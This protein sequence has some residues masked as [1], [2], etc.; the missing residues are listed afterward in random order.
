[1]SSKNVNFS[2]Q[3][4]L[5]NVTPLVIS[6]NVQQVVPVEGTPSQYDPVSRPSELQGQPKVTKKLKI[7]VSK[8][9]SATIIQSHQDEIQQQQML[10]NQTMQ[11]IHENHSD[12][13]QFTEV[14]CG[15]TSTRAIKT[16]HNPTMQQISYPGKQP[17]NALVPAQQ[18]YPQNAIAP[19]T[20]NALVP[21]GL[22]SQQKSPQHI[23]VPATQSHESKKKLVAEHR[24]VSEHVE[25]R[26]LAE[27]FTKLPS[28]QP[29]QIVQNLEA[30]PS[31]PS[32]SVQHASNALVLKADANVIA[33]QPVPSN[34]VGIRQ[35]KQE[36]DVQ[37]ETDVRGKVDDREYL[38]RQSDVYRDEHEIR[39]IKRIVSTP[40]GDYEHVQLVAE[41]RVL[42]EA[43]LQLYLEAENEN[44]PDEDQS[45]TVTDDD[46][47]VNPSSFERC[48]D[49]VCQSCTCNFRNPFSHQKYDKKIVA[50]N[51]IMTP[52]LQRG[53]AKGTTLLKHFVFPLV[54]PLVRIGWIICELIFVLITII[55]SIV[56]FAT[57]NQ[58]V[59][60]IVQ[61]ILAFVSCLLAVIDIFYSLPASVK[62]YKLIKKAEEANEGSTIDA[63]TVKGT[64]SKCWGCNNFCCN[65]LETL[66]DVLRTI[67]TEVILVPLILCDIFEVVISIPGLPDNLE[68]F[69]AIVLFA[70]G[71]IGIVLYVY[72]VRLAIL[73]GIIHYVYKARRAFIKDSKSLTEV[74]FDQAKAMD[75]LKFKIFFLIHVTGQMICQVLMLV[76][77][78]RRI[79]IE[80]QHFYEPNNL[81]TS[82][83]VS[84]QLWYMCAAVTIL[85][86]FGFFTFFVVANFWVQQFPISF[87]LGLITALK[88]PGAQEMCSVKQISKANADQVLKVINKFVR[89]FKLKNQFHDMYYVPFSKKLQYPFRSPG[90][91]F[92]C[93]VYFAAHMCFAAFALVGE[94]SL[95]E[96][97]AVGIWDLWSGFYVVAGFIGFV[98]N[99]YAFA[100]PIF[101][102]L[103]ITLFIA[104]ICLSI[105]LSGGGSTRNGRR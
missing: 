101:W 18:V 92:I 75:A 60:N 5:P 3:L 64:C 87:C 33:R 56:S 59:F 49:I 25:Q 67:L 91:I 8:Q 66:S 50:K 84:S 28:K 89:V 94:V 48:T 47:E 37:L 10:Q 35:Q 100:V 2:K 103:V 81:D 17:Q 51:D 63:S 53:R 29:M 13:T 21:V 20:N 82:I 95:S 9:K 105:C 40:D 102:I 86:V 104:L 11:V 88:S 85:P 45:T 14:H 62:R 52:V 80:N 74:G 96:N 65:C 12:G 58:N 16:S 55:F 43:I 30:T 6:G 76:T 27:K 22:Q 71:L 36:I 79:Y 61:L 93:S 83:K 69:F 39:E 31:L 78:G 1:M 73:V 70:I 77:V 41:R 15:P 23:V 32:N 4:R 90:M 68:S 26:V 99:I 24:Q 57:S 98:L 44:N 46:P 54:G 7:G 42:H 38:V 19:A 97:E 34:A 72:F